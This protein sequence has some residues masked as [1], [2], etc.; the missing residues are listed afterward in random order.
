MSKARVVGTPEEIE[1]IARAHG[2]VPRMS[3]RR[4]GGTAGYFEIKAPKV[5][6]LDCETTGLSPVDDEILTLSIVDWAGETL[7]D[8]KFKP[9]HKTEWPEAARIN[10]IWPKDVADC[11]SFFDETEYGKMR[12]TVWGADEIIA[13][14]AKFDL[15]LLSYNDVAPNHETKITDTMLEFAREYGDWDE[16]HDGWKWHKLV[17]AC[18]FIGYEWTGRAHGSLADA[19]AC[20]AVQKWV[21]KRRRE[22]E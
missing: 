7:Y 11:P 18:E 15:G 19:R 8:G 5:I 12:E 10:G 14:N 4:D 17:D 9:V 22:E 21:E 16:C 2:A 6:C 20:L 13:Y 1:L 3:K